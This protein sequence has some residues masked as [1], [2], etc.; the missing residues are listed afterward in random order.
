MQFDGRENK[1]KQIDVIQSNDANWHWRSS[2]ND[3]IVLFFCCLVNT[4]INL[5]LGYL[6]WHKLD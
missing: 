6:F 2:F 1:R 3:S 4:I 5:L